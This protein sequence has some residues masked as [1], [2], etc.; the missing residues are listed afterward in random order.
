MRI[1][2]DSIHILDSFATGSRVYG[3]PREDSDFDLAVLLHEG[4]DELWKI[5]NLDQGKG[6]SIRFGVLNLIAFT[7]RESFDKW[8]G[9][10]EELAKRAPVTRDEAIAA[11][12][13]QGFSDYGA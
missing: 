3:T 6:S 5:A 13:A 7:D 4:A 12:Q 8:R 11:F 10:T 9:V 1:R 2:F